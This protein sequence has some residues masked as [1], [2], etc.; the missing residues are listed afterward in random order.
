MI[1][2]QWINDKF[3]RGLRLCFHRRPEMLGT[4]REA[5][6]AL[7]PEGLILGANRSA[8]ELLGLNVAAL[9]ML[10]LEAVLGVTVAAL[11]DYFRRAH[12]EPIRLHT[13]YVDAGEVA[14]Y[15]RAQF[16]WPTRWRVVAPPAPTA[17]AGKPARVRAAATSTLQAQ[18]IA[19]IRRAVDA[20]GGNISQAARQLGVAR[21]TVYRK[22]RGGTN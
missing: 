22:L 21:N 15:A 4:V 16:N 3:R 18:E 13:P 10:G 1:E 19:A 12:D 7:S 17:V 8:I 14:L 2:H 20:A 5:M 11:A 9:R 6:L